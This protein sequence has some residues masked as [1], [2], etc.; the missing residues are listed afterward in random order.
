MKVNGAVVVVTGAS[1]LLGQTTSRALR[2]AGAQVLTIGPR[3]YDLRR[4]REVRDMLRS[5]RPEAV[6][7]VAKQAPV[8][9]SGDAPRA[10]YEAVIVGVELIEACRFFGVQRLLLGEIR[11]A[12]PRVDPEPAP[13]QPAGPKS[14]EAVD[15]PVHRMLDAQGALYRQQTSLDV[16]LLSLSNLYA[17][18]PE[19]GAEEAGWSPASSRPSRVPWLMAGSRFRCGAK[20]RPRPGCC[21]STRPRA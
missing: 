6:I 10:L 13:R 2:S 1:G 21:M 14:P 9:V 16:S 5:I 12:L 18:D 17:P 7:H 19:Y 15:T 20:P 4:Q 8:A 11:S 3:D